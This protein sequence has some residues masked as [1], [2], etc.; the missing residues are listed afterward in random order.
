MASASSEELQ[1]LYDQALDLLC[2]GEADKAIETYITILD[3]DPKYVDA[4]HDLAHA[5]ADKDMLD[6]AIE[7]AK[8]LIILTP[9]DAMGF[10]ILSRFYQLK[11]MI[12]E[13]EAEAAKARVLDWK[14]ELKEK[15]LGG[16]S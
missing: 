12:P 10:T 1:D 2:D 11:D 6:E 16:G 13:A 7:A 14:R 9:D 3:I 5:Y 4:V 8:Q 15:K